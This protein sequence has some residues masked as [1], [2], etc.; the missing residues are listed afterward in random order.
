MS[1]RKA[2]GI[3][4]GR[5]KSAASVCKTQRSGRFG[6]LAAGL[7]S[8]GRLSRRAE[9]RRIDSLG[10]LIRQFDLLRER[11]PFF[12]EAD[13]RGSEEQDPVFVGNV[14]GT[15]QVNASGFVDRRVD[16]GLNQF[17]KLFVEGVEIAGR[18]LVQNNQV[19]LKSVRMPE[20]VGQQELAQVPAMF[21]LGDSNDDD[22]VVA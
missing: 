1:G 10:R 2:N 12:G 19:D 21:R 3:F 9:D 8:A 18:V 11:S 15:H 14:C 13:G 20:L 5:K 16:R 7:D 4:A 6:W 17:E 22:R